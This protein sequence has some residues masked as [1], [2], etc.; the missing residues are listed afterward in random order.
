MYASMIV[1]AAFLFASLAAVAIGVGAAVA[2]DER[3]QQPAVIELFTSQGCASCPSADTLISELARD[4]PNLIALTL[5][6]DY[7]DYIGW[8]DTLA[9]PAFTARQR[10]YASLRGDQQIYTPQAVINGL[11]HVV[12]SDREEIKASARTAF[13]KDGALSVALAARPEASGLSVELGAAPPGAA[14]TGELWLFHIARERTV[15]IGRGENAGNRVTYANVVRHMRKIGDWTGAPARF[16]IAPDDLLAPDSDS[17]VL[18]LQAGSMEKPGPI[19]AATSGDH[20][21]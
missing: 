20:I 6:I 9:L 4:H 21:R 16:S 12:G 18:I 15:S 19:L 13:G 2:R 14:R 1:R 5:P 11:S 17:Y 7:W 3:Q 10:A 8:K